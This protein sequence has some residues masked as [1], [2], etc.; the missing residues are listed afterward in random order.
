MAIYAVFGAAGNC[1]SSL[2]QVLLLS[3]NTKINAYC[4]N[5]AKFTRMMPNVADSKRV[6]IFEGQ[7]DNVDLFANCIRGCKAVFFTVSMNDNVPGCRVSQDTTITLLPALR[8]LKAEAD[9]HTQMPKI[10]VLSSSSL[11]HKLCR[12]TL[13]WFH[14]NILRAN[15]NVYEDLRRQERMLRA[16]QDWLSN[17]FSKSGGLICDTRR[18]HRLDLDKQETFVSYLDL[19]AGMVDAAE[20]PEDRYDMKDVSV[21]NIGGSAK[22]PPLLP[23][24]FIVGILR[25]F[26]PWLYPYLPLLG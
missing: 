25:H 1:G 18:G 8:K 2:I 20:D 12:N 16:E 6:Q 4:R 14:W 22:F 7:I 21:N 10:V 13:A 24:L 5:R 26:F 17:I 9:P 15:S 11:E 19:A 3:P 23:L